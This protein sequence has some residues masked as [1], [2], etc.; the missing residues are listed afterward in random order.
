[1][2]DVSALCN[3]DEFMISMRVIL[4]SF[5]HAFALPHDSDKL[6]VA[7][8]LST[9][10]GVGGVAESTVRWVCSEGFVTRTERHDYPAEKGRCLG[11]PRVMS[12]RGQTSVV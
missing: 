5:L 8:S 2:N 6:S 9:L 10:I 1:M 3:L 12:G 4:R 11:T 7:E